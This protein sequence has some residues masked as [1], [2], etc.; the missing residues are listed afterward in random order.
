MLE[1]V[2]DLVRPLWYTDPVF[3]RLRFLRATGVWEGRLFFTPINADIE[4]FLTDSP[5]GPGEDQHKW[6]EQ[7][8]QRFDELL[9]DVIPV[10]GRAAPASQT[11][12]DSDFRLVAVSLSSMTTEPPYWELTFERISTSGQYDVTM[13]GWVPTRVE[14]E[15]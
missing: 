5:H 15:L 4:L 10:L 6:F 2:K 8:L 7:L 14:P 13:E 3:G 11:I 9:G 12:S 1:W